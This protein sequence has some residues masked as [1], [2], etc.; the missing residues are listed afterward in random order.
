MVVRDLGLNLQYEKG[1]R[2]T[3]SR[4]WHFSTDGNF[5]DVLFYDD[6]DFADGMNRIFIVLKRFNVVILAFCLMD[7][8]IHFC[9]Y[10]ELEEC[11]RFVHEYMRRLSM[12]IRSRHGIPN[13]CYRIPIGYQVVDNDL[14]L[15]NVICYIIK[16]PPVAGLPHLAHDYPWSSGGLYFRSGCGWTEPLW[17]VDGTVV[18]R[19]LS[20]RQRLGILK[21]S[22]RIVGNVPMIGGLVSPEEYVAVEVVEKIFRT[23]RAFNFFMCSTKESDVELMSG[24]VSRLSLPDSELRQHKREICKKYFGVESTYTLNTKQRLKVAKAL[25]A[26][27]NCS[28][29]QVAKITGLVYSEVRNLI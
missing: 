15:K 3:V 27:F 19:A 25:R 6:V 28:V 1:K 20:K 10:G 13:K 9:L 7:N 29:K 11:R 5:A 22:E 2:I 12:S 23:H 17:K 4:C 18:G 26:R 14:Y 8:H 21:S 24:V 16:N